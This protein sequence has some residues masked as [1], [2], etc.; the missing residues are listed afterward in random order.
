MKL[1]HLH[2]PKHQLTQD[3]QRVVFIHHWRGQP[4]VWIVPWYYIVS[5]KD[6]PDG[7]WQLRISERYW[8]HAMNDQRAA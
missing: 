6:S 3:Y 2:I 8:T 5:L 4:L 7:A 1:T